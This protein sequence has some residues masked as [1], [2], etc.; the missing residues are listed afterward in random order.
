MTIE[1]A[2]RTLEERVEPLERFIR[3]FA[4]SLEQPFFEQ[5]SDISAFRYAK[6]D[7][8]HFCLLKGVKAL[9]ALNASFAHARSGYVQEASVLI[10]TLMEATR[11]IEYV[12]DLDDSKE[13]KATVE[14]YMA[15]YFADTDRAAGAEM[16]R[17]PIQQGRVHEQLGKTLDEIASQGKGL[18]NR[19][20]AKVMYKRTYH[21]LSGY[22]HGSYP[23]LMDLYGNRPGYFH[24][25]GM[26]GTL[27]DGE[28]LE[29]LDAFIETTMTSF[30]IM[31]QQLN[32]RAFV[33][34]DALI[35]AWYRAYFAR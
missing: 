25:Q 34:G 24:M 19:V 31:I 23:E 5:D 11:H 3:L 33:D 32:L 4:A 9:S 17:A 35:G 29:Q 30:V 12:L 6:P 1:I 22:V 15:E 27:K 7:V 13:H 10:R 16:K 21:R 14:K 8:R 2:I 28:M 18:E 26:S 20:S